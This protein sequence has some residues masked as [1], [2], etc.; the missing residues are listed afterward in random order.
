M[1]NET[2]FFLLPC[3]WDWSKWL[4]VS[5]LFVVLLLGLLWM[6]SLDSYHWRTLGLVPIW[7][8]YDCRKH[9]GKTFSPQL[10]LTA[11]GFEPWVLSI[12]G[13]CMFFELIDHLQPSCF[14][15]SKEI[16]RCVI[17]SS[18]SQKT[19]KLFSGF[20]DGHAKWFMSP[21]PPTPPHVW[22]LLTGHA[23]CALCC[24]H[25]L[26]LFESPCCLHLTILVG[27]GQCHPLVLIYVS[28]W[29][30]ILKVFH[31][32]FHHSFVFG[33][34]FFLDFLWKVFEKYYWSSWDVV[35]W[36]QRSLLGL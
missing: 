12:L 19:D 29:L 25:L 21:P 32:F 11:L 22:E 7:G 31:L 9:S 30:V 34:N 26:C 28:Q 3:L 20:R 27:T 13:K 33:E 10:F 16:C 4:C 8:A 18:V 2:A 14:C 1:Y 15:F 36:E 5:I 6:Y 23:P 24:V 17:L 35:Y